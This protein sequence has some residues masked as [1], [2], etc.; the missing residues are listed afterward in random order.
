M[1]TEMCLVICF[2]VGVLVFYL[3]KQ[4]CG[5]AAVVEGQSELIS[6][7]LDAV[8]G[9]ENLQTLNEE[10]DIVKGGALVGVGELNLD[11]IVSGFERIG[12]GTGHNTSSTP[13]GCCISS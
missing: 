5:C 13:P 7:S 4:S 10:I 8:F 12:Q 2:L 3:L 1:K 11:N 9:R 6:P